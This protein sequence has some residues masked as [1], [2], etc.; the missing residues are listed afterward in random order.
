[1]WISPCHEYSSQHKLLVMTEKFRESVDKGNTFGAILTD[2]KAFDCIDLTL[3][4]A[5]LFTFGVL[6]LS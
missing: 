6:P 2:L 3:F 1:M 4:I 5:K